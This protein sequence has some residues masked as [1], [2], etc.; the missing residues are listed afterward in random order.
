MAEGKRSDGPHP[1]SPGVV[2][3]QPDVSRAVSW[4]AQVGAA[5]G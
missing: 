2:T 4:S 1:V 3:M 5:R